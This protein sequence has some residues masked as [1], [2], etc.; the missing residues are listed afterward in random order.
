METLSDLIV[1]YL[2]ALN[3][4]YVFGVPGGAVEPIYN[5]LARSERDGGPRAVLARHEAGAAFMADGYARETGKLGVC[6]ATSGP[7][8]TNLISGIAN[9]YDNSI[10][11]LALTGCPSIA[12]WGQGALQESSCTGVNVLNMFNSCT[13]FNTLISHEDQG[14]RK[15]TSAIISALNPTRGPVHL[16]IPVDVQRAIVNQKTNPD[17]FSGLVLHQAEFEQELFSIVETL[18]SAVNPVVLIGKG[19]NKR[20]VQHIVQLC[21]S[22]DVRF[23]ASP[24]A[25]QFINHSHRL[26]RG[27][28]GFAG[29][30]SAFNLFKEELDVIIAVGVK[31][32]E[33]T[34]GAW[35]EQLLSNKLIH[36]DHAYDNFLRSPMARQH[37]RGNIELIFERLVQIN[38]SLLIKNSVAHGS[39]DILE[40]TQQPDKA[41]SD[42]TPIKPQRLMTE[43][44]K[45][46]NGAQF[47]AD[48][49]N[50]TCWAIQYLHNRLDVLMDFAPMGWAIGVSVGK[51]ISSK[52]PV[53]CIVGDGSYLMS[54]QEI[55]VA[56]KEELCVI[57]VVLNDAALGMVKHGQRLANSEEHCFE[58]PVIDY[59]EMAR[60]AG[61][62][63]H[64]IT[65]PADFDSIDCA[66]IMRRKGPTLLDVR[67]DG[68]EV[69]PMNLRLLALHA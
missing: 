37:V 40:H 25:L 53:V 39:F 6:I 17:L 18:R 69:P 54:G 60:S 59:A 11:V 29:H 42:D 58:L 43:L 52:A 16:S 50:G 32:G 30:S 1:S 34:S 24:D 47:V 21:D 28:F 12:L 65:D 66:E 45:R 23:A 13:K 19:C 2:R 22:L 8:A 38:Q 57:Y 63:G 49:G 26:Y 9:A 41:V 44:S 5:A 51:A 61:I 20:A 68:E 64:V 62:P 7:G 48:P 56:A 15:L 36:I 35:N 10:S 3:I 67:I 27:A 4:E 14:E 46:F 55:T 33:W 31:L